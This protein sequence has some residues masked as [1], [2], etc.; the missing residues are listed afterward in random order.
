MEALAK[1]CDRLLAYNNEFESVEELEK[2]VNTFNENINKEVSQ[3][4]NR[5]VN[6][7]FEYEKE[8]LLPLP[9]QKIF[10]AYLSNR[11]T[12]KVAKDSMISY[13]GNKYSVPVKYI[14]FDLSIIEKDNNLYIYDSTNLV[15]CHT[16]SNNSLNYN[17]EDIKDIL[18]S[19]L[20]R[21]SSEEKIE[22][23]IEENLSQYDQ[24]LY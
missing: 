15:R 14:S 7:V 3:A 24:L 2:I 16:I 5:V 12:R 4:H 18:A 11:E 17:N 21:N 8:Y 10:S 22:Q 20:L 19:D 23:F 9:N 6:E 1:L 13:K